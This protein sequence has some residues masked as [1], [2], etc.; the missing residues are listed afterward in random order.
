MFSNLSRPTTWYTVKRKTF[1][2]CFEHA[3]CILIDIF[4]VLANECL[5]APGWGDLT[6]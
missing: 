2:Q 1:V 3:E 5:N 4:D 6:M